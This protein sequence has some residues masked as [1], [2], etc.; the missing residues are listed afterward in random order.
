M[1]EQRKLQSAE[2]ADADYDGVHCPNCGSDD[3]ETAGP[4]DGTGRELWAKV[5]CGG[6]GHE[7]TEV[8]DLRGTIEH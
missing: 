2:Q 7:Y 6:C 3:L 1:A 5:A 4:N 8:Y